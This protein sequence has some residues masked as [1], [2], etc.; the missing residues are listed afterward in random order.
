[1]GQL[2]CDSAVGSNRQE[3]LHK[4]REA[5]IVA[6]SFVVLITSAADERC[7]NSFRKRGGL[8][9]V[10]EKETR[11]AARIAY[12]MLEEPCMLGWAVRDR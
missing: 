5:H 8:R 9:R 12:S 11:V 6:V 1:M 2:V 3:T 7:M 4:G 10:R